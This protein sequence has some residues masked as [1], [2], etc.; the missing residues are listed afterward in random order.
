M[1]ASQKGKKNII[2]IFSQLFD[3]KSKKIKASNVVFIFMELLLKK[4][5]K[6]EMKLKNIV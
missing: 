6:L 4:G 1:I 5:E 2:R 3:F